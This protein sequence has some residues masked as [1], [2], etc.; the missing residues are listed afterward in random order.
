MERLKE[1]QETGYMFSHGALQRILPPLKDRVAEPG[2]AHSRMKEVARN[3][4][5]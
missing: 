5:T 3:S 1:V 2:Q 4:L